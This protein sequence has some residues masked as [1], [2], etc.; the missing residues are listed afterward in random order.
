MEGANVVVELL[1]IVVVKALVVVEVDVLDLATSGDVGL[2][3]EYEDE[4]VVLV[5][6]AAAVDVDD[7]WISATF[8]HHHRH[9]YHH[10][11]MTN[12]VAPSKH[13]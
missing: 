12:Y 4:D 11:I 7:S 13:L 8:R 6:G 9:H 10:I 3:D 1:G 5:D 2:V